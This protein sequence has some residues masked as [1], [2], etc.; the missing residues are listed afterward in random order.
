MQDKIISESGEVWIYRLRRK[1][2]PGKL[3]YILFSPTTSGKSIKNFRFKPEAEQN[4]S[5]TEV[6]LD[7]KSAS[8]VTKSLKVSGGTLEL[9]VNESPVFLVGN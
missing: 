6:R 1:D 9:T 7:D 3:A 4:Q 8:G 5:F 2:N